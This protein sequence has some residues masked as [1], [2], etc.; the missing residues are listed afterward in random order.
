ML[1]ISIVNSKEFLNIDLCVS[2]LLRL[3]L[4]IYLSGTYVIFQMSILLNQ[5]LLEILVGT[6][7]FFNDSLVSIKILDPDCLVVYLYEDAARR[8]DSLVKVVV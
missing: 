8:I 7:M 5:S 2:N 3:F 4:G 1:Q 6:F